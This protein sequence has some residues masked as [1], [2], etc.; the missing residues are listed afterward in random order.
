MLKW[1]VTFLFVILLTHCGK[2]TP[3]ISG[4]DLPPDNLAPSN[5]LTPNGDEANSGTDNLEV[6]VD[7]GVKVLEAPLVLLRGNIDQY[8][9]SMTAA[10]GA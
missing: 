7:D 1:S 2:P 4:V 8:S 5:T 9:T 3:V 10:P 6:V